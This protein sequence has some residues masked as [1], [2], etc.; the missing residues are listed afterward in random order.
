M[1]RAEFFILDDGKI[2]GFDISGH[3]GY[4]ESGKDIV[5]AAVSSAAYMTANTIADVMGIQAEVTVKDDEGHMNFLV[6]D[7]YLSDCGYILQGFKNHLLML[8][9]MYPENVKVFYKEV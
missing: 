4:E 7:K 9:E 5:C 1:L 2:K 8:E 3:S 6:Y